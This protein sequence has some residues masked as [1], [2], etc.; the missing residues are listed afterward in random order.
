MLK[1]KQWF[2]EQIWLV[3]PRLSEMNAKLIYTLRLLWIIAK[4][5]VEDNCLLRAQALAYTT[6]ISLVPLL[7]VAFSIFKGIGGIENAKRDLAPLLSTV[8]VPESQEAVHSTLFGFIDKINATAIGG[9]AFVFLT[10]SVLSLL[11][12]IEKAFNSIWGVVRSRNLFE[13]LTSYWAVLTFGP[14]LIVIS[15]SLSATLQSSSIYDMLV[16]LPFL[17]VGIAYA[18]TIIVTAIAFFLLYIYMPNTKVRIVPAIIGSLCAAVLFEGA[19]LIFALYVKGVMTPDSPMVKIYG[20]FIALPIFLLWIW[21]IWLIVLLGAEVSFAWQ[22]MKNFEFEGRS[23]KSNFSSELFTALVLC[24]EAAKEFYGEKRNWD[25]NVLAESYSIPVRLINE[26]SSS[27]VDGGIVVYAEHDTQKALTPAS[28]PSQI[29]V[30]Q[31]HRVIAE[32]GFDAIKGCDLDLRSGIQALL[33][34]PQTTLQ[35]Y[36]KTL[37]ATEPAVVGN[38]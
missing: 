14:V 8:L 26:V 5:F 7:A 17:G 15:I 20:G 22:N 27:L 18:F 9:I 6:A 38:G 35:A 21:L 34:Q 32:A 31:I 12:T 28:D 1:P 29:T 13:R 30:S 36:S 2:V 33:N 37:S 25:V 4:G 24:A 23:T 19:K 3:P 16:T 11:G 10:V